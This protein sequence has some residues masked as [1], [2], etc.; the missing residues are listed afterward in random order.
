ML[1]ALVAFPLIVPL[2]LYERPDVR[3]HFWYGRL[4][5]RVWSFQALSSAR[6]VVLYPA[7][8]DK[9]C[10]LQ[11]FIGWAE[12]D[13]DTFSERFGRRFRR[14]LTVVLVSSYQDLLDDFGRHIGGIALP[15][16]PTI[17]LVADGA[18]RTYLRHELAHLFSFLWSMVPP[19]LLQEGLAEWLERPEPGIADPTEDHA[20]NRDLD[21]DPVPLLD[22]RHF[23]A[24]G[25]VNRS[26]VQ[27]GIFT[28]FLIRR[29]GWDRYRLF[30]RKATRW[31]FRSIFRKHFGVNFEEAWHRCRDE[32]VAM[33]SLIKRRETD[34]LFN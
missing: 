29:F 14:R 27:A 18:L 20:A 3:P 19:P 21:D 4:T 24:T 9:T 34:R 2:A 5:R 32:S 11:Q 17:V 26:Y 30:Y 22:P 23:F 13:L 7:G 28:G 12:S 25:Y 31:R 6:V 33:A 15:F 16:G 10:D 1:I 8:L